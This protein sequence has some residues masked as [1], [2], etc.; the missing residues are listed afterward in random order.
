[1]KALWRFSDPGD[2]SFARASRRGT[3][4]GEPQVR[5]RPLVMEWEAGSDVIGDFTWPGFDSDIVIS[6]RAAQALLQAGIPGFELSNIEL[7]ETR[8]N[9]RALDKGKGTVRLPYSGP[10]LWD[11]WVTE[12]A[13]LDRERSTITCDH[14]GGTPQWEVKGVEWRE[15]VWDSQLKMLNKILHPRVEGQGLFVRTARG[16]F[17]VAEFPGWIFCSDDVK[18][19]IENRCFTNVSFL[20]MGDE[21]SAS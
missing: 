5:I 19:L 10:V 13:A 7:V 4:H 11:L 6:D 20:Q 15:A 21:I 12:T 18:T 8:K 14:E 17:R 3:W 16:I 1:M 2:F 9:V